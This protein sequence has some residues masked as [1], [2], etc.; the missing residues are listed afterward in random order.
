V[1]GD[2]H[3]NRTCNLV[4][5]NSHAHHMAIHYRQD[6]LRES[7]DANNLKCDY[8]K[9]WDSPENVREI[10][11]TNGRKRRYHAKC[12]TESQRRYR[13]RRKL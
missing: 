7:G 8:C 12:N 11:C 4:I 3:D 2:R 13:K 6:A 5:C 1:N 10:A 9:Q